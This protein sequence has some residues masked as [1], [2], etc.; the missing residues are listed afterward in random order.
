M[1]TNCKTKSFT[2][3]SD[4]HLTQSRLYITLELADFSKDML[5]SMSRSEVV[6]QSFASIALYR[7]EPRRSIKP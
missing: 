5:M 7:S 2:V 6:I 4:L 3:L 1:S